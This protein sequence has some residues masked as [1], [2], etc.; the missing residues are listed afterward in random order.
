MINWWVLLVLSLAYV[1]V[2]F[3][4]AYWGDVADSRRFSRFGRSVIYSLT[5]A[6]YCTSWT[7][8]GAVGTAADSGWGY[9]PIYI[10]PMLVIL[11]GWP[12]INRIVT[13]SKRQNLTSIADFI[14]ARYGK[15]QSLA[16]LVTVIATVGS[17]PY[18]ALQLKAVVAGFNIG[19]ELLRSRVAQATTRRSCSRSALAVFAILFGTR[20]IDVT[21]HHDGHDARYRVRVGRQAARLRGRRLVR[22]V[23]G[24]SVRTAADRRRPRR[25]VFNARHGCLTRS[26][27]S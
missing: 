27:R 6:V 23:H 26:S 8:Y 22:P 14:A 11:L 15:A 1:T 7:F 20:K 2:L 18:I 3:A 5:L 16:A 4:I 19:L 25:T 21:E 12:L 10:A 17:V 13:I 24:D 9:L